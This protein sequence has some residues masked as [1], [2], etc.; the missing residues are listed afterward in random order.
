MRPEHVWNKQ[1]KN[2]REKKKR[3][4]RPRSQ[5]RT[6]AKRSGDSTESDAPVGPTDASSPLEGGSEAA[7]LSENEVEN[8]VESS[9]K[10]VVE[11]EDEGQPQLP[12]MPERQIASSPKAYKPPSKVRSHGANS[13]ADGASTRTVQSSPP[14]DTGADGQ[15][16]DGDLTPKPT[17]RL[18]FP[19]PRKD[20]EVKT[21]GEL[22]VNRQQGEFRRSPRINRQKIIPGL[23]K[24]PTKEK[25]NCAPSQGD[26]LSHLFDEEGEHE[27]PAPKT[28]TPTR[29]SARILLKTP[30]KTPSA[31]KAVIPAALSPAAQRLLHTLRTPKGSECRQRAAT[32]LLGNGT[33]A[34]PFTLQLNQLL[35]D[36]IAKTSPAGP[37]SE[38]NF[39]FPDLPSLRS[40][41]NPGHGNGANFDFSEFSNFDPSDLDNLQELLSTDLPMPSSPPN[42]FFNM[43]EDAA[44]EQA[45]IWSDF[46]CPEPASM[47]PPAKR[48]SPRRKGGEVAVDFSHFVDEVAGGQ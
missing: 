46:A 7:Q 13:K 35:S 11:N 25:E 48:V 30:S 16:A 27:P 33:D 36:A 38:L 22:S 24:T 2:P 1:P 15:A 23:A 4:S 9:Q 32:A 39:D 26:G 31:M 8:D 10:D 12:P 14:Q 21:L 37:N 40:S 47:A 44:G 28:P 5:R 42:T 45:G 29:R 34:T 41:P 18:L 6:T 17:R 43:Y 19:S 3:P 20:G